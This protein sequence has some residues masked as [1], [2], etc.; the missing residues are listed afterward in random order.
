MTMTNESML[1]KLIPGAILGF[2]VFVG[3]ALLGDIRQ[4]S[5]M[6]VHFD[7]RVFPLVLL[8]TTFNDGLRFIKWHLYIR[9]LGIRHISWLQSLQIFT[10]GLPLSVTP[11]KVGE[12][13]KGVWL[14]QR[15]GVPVGRGVSVV[16][17]ERISD[18]LAV[19]GLSTLGVMAYPQYWMVFALVLA[20]LL[21]VVLL[22]QIRPAA[23][24]VLGICERLPLVRRF[25]FGIREF[26]EGSFSLFQLKPTLAAVSIGLISWLGEGIGFYL[27][28]RALGLPASRELLGMAVFVLAFSTVVGAISAL[29]GGL[30]A[31]EVSVAGML[32]LLM[33]VDPAIATSATI[34]IRLATLWFGVALGLM[35]WG[36]SPGLLGLHSQNESIVE[37]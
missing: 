12:A 9:L 14:K 23:L 19:L 26:Y 32:T 36:F 4:V 1:R 33:G 11:G 17:A 18:G 16:V 8:L 5:R 37:G 15:S 10:A 7:W 31:V 34:L 27:I 2:L 22:S 6:M 24:W 35:V 20:A 28:L 29:P 3:L 13:L 30:G 21:G 25:A